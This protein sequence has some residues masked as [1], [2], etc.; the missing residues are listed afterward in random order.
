MKFN[1]NYFIQYKDMFNIYNLIKQIN[2]GY[3][4]YFCLKDKLF[5]IININN[6]FEI[7]YSFNSFYNNII[8]NLRFSKID[9]IN[10]I[11]TEIDIFNNNLERKTI[12]STKQ[13]TLDKIK[14]FNYISNRLY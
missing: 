3:R 7:C 1:K 12:E 6:N 2:N 13:L 14:E 10:K 8:S 11:L 5:Y 9:N 4:L